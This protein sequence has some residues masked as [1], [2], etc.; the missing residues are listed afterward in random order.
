MADPMAYPD[1]DRAE[2]KQIYKAVTGD[3]ERVASFAGPKAL[4]AHNTANRYYRMRMEK[5][6]D[7]MS[8]MVEKKWDTQAYDLAFSGTKDS[9]QKLRALRRNIVF[10]EKDGSVN[11]K[12][13]DTIA[14]STLHRM[15]QAKPGASGAADNLFSPETFLSNWKGMSREA[16]EALFGGTQYKQLDPQLKRL[17]RLSASLRDLNKTRNF[18]NTARAM[19]VLGLFS[20]AGGVAGAA[21]GGGDWKSVAAGA[22]IP[23]IAPYAAAKLLTHAPFVKWVADSQTK[24]IN[25]KGW[26]GHIGRLTAIAHENPDIREEVHQFLSA[27]K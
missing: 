4:K 16:R 6:I 13:W 27:L 5:D 3:M 25:T 21:V 17:T 9:G 11:K 8:E 20:A 2:L 1:M 26:A 15:G 23:L 14:A 18:S 22:S 19:G 7:L 24:A 10:K 12:A